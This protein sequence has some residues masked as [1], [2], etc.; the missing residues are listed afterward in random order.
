MTN[1][2]IVPAHDPIAERGYLCSVLMV[3]PNFLDQHPVEA[4]A[5]FV[6]AHR[7]VYV[8]ARTLYDAGKA[9]TIPEV[10]LELERT[11]DLERSG[12]FEAVYD[13]SKAFEFAGSVGTCATRL[14]SL[15]A[16]RQRQDGLQ[17]ALASCAGGELSVVDAAISDLASGVGDC[18]DAPESLYQSAVSVFEDLSTRKGGVHL[19]PTTLAPVDDSVAGLSA[20]SMMVV[21]ADTG[22]GKTG[23]LLAMALGM[24]REHRRRVGIISCEDGRDVMGTRAAGNSADVDGRRL[25]S[26]RGITPEEWE[27]LA[28]AVEGFRSL[29]IELR[30][31]I[32]GND[33]DVAAAMGQLVKRGAE[34]VMVDYLQAIN[35][36][37]RAD[38][39]REAI[40]QVASR[41]KGRA[42]RLGVPLVVTSQLSRPGKDETMREPSRHHLKESGDIENMAEL[43]VMLWKHDAM[44][45]NAVSAKLDKSK[46]G[47][48]GARWQMV[49]R[50]GVLVEVNE[51]SWGS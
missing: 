45:H 10:V 6:A 26:G 31:C 19:V 48:D 51:R 44:D 5:F 11:R 35:C 23:V 50:H 12:G 36:S 13:L 25:R 1:H 15:A 32:G 46:W 22:V 27:R 21:G 8:A 29:P 30:Y 34:I 42:F 24:A 47:G 3:D 14:R 7:R 40:R 33:I 18:D 49:R 38:V 20:G 2:A 4:D 17:R 9:V 39:R 16:L 43:I 28:R 37:G 41:L